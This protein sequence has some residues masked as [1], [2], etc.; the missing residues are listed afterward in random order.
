[1]SFIRKL[2]RILI[3]LSFFLLG[4]NQLQH[5]QQAILDTERRMKE[6]N[7]FSNQHTKQYFTIKDTD[8]K[9]IPA[10]VFGCAVLKIL[11]GIGSLYKSKLAVISGSL[12][13]ISAIFVVSNPFVYSWTYSIGFVGMLGA[14]LVVRN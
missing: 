12:Y 14:L 5:P 7:K 6:F 2:A 1:M 4:V 11:V 10:I 3:C 8:P 13:V 9:Y